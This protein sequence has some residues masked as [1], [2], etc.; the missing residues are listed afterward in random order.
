MGISK[1]EQITSSHL[2]NEVHFFV[3]LIRGINT[4]FATNVFKIKEIIK[5]EGKLVDIFSGIDYVKGVI[6]IRGV[7]IPVMDLG[8]WLKNQ[9]SETDIIMV[10]DFLG[11]LV[12]IMISKPI[13]I[14]IISWD[15]FIRS[16]NEKI[17]GYFK[18]NEDIVEIVDLEKMIV[19]AF[20]EIEHHSEI[21]KVENLDIEKVILVADD[22]KLVLKTLSKILDKINVRYKLFSNGEELLN[23]LFTIS[24]NEVFA[25]ITDLEMPKKS[26]FEVI[27]EVKNSEQYSKIPIIV[28]S[29]M[30]GESNEEMAKS[31]NAEGFVS[32]NRPKEI[33]A[34]LKKFLKL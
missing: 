9:E 15:K 6:D 3:F 21:D 32:K 31:L 22:S 4:K 25:I 2:R 26:G 27:K 18:D 11:I 33:E 7:T 23:Y 19:E 29:T 24:P 28:N 5:Y 30:S 10:C 8:L 20:P 13:G 12:G 1:I 17:I 34:Y 16:D 14:K